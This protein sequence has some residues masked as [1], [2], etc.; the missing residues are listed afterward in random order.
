MTLL[1]CVASSG[2]NLPKVRLADSWPPRSLS[3]CGRRIRCATGFKD[4][5]NPRSET[6]DFVLRLWR[7]VRFTLNLLVQGLRLVAFALL[8]L[9]ACLRIGWFYF[10]NPRIARAIA[11]GAK[12]R[13]FLD[14]YFPNEAAGS[15]P[16]PV[17]VAVM[18]GAW[19]I[20]HRLWNV[21]LA[22]RLAE[23]GVM[24][25][26]V[27]YR[28]F[29]LATIPE[30]LDD[31]DTALKW[32]QSNVA[33]YG[34]DTSRMALVGQS[35]GAHL[36][37]A[38][39]LRQ[40]R[41]E[42][43]DMESARCLGWSPSDFQVFLGVSGFYDLPKEAAHMESIGIFPFLPHLCV[44]GDMAAVSPTLLV[45]EPHLRHAA[46]RMPPVQLMH[47][48]ADTSVPHE[49]STAFADALL[50][51]G[52]AD[53]EVELFENVTHSHPVVEGPMAGEDYQARL[54]LRRLGLPLPSSPSVRWLPRP[55]V[56]VASKV[57]PF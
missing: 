41:R 11:Y 9:P 19:T 27:D 49:M 54:L 18:G 43:E 39:L 7:F 45:Q 2:A 12:P 24:V 3:R 32:V 52:V 55:V 57:M 25:V 22:A 53:V 40:C 15:A 26:A 8:I 21:L 46:S 50:K 5:R 28:N 17:V 13:Q 42:E 38:L 47:G 36:C 1:P 20:G 10:R 33:S 48:K 23:A 44:D 29:P 56:A 6:V 30:M 37:S 31:L 51:A 4:R 34:G 16:R 35:A 14:V